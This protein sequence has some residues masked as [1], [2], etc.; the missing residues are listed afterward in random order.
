M[1]SDR[2]NR[3]GTLLRMVVVATML[4]TVGLTAVGATP[5][6]ATTSGPQAP[7]R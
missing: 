6:S 2:R 1:I 3:K 4:A 7:R 5:A